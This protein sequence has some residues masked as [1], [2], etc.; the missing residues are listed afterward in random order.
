MKPISTGGASQ[1]SI[2]DAHP[3]T[4][5]S[6]TQPYHD[7]RSATEATH[8]EGIDVAVRDAGRPVDTVMLM[9]D[10]QPKLLP[11]SAAGIAF[12]EQKSED[13]TVISARFG[14]LVKE[15]NLLRMQLQTN[16]SQQMADQMDA[17][18]TRK[19]DQAEQEREKAERVQKIWGSVFKGLTVLLTAASLLAA[20]FTGGATLV[21]TMAIFA[22]DVGMEVGTGKSLTAR[23]VEPVMKFAIETFQKLT[24]ELEKLGLGKEAAIAVAAALSY[25]AVN[26]LVVVLAKV[27]GG[28]ATAAKFIGKCTPKMVQLLKQALQWV[29]KQIGKI[30]V[31]DGGF[32]A[33]AKSVGYVAGAGTGLSQTGNAGQAVAQAHHHHEAAKIEASIVSDSAYRDINNE[34]SEALVDMANHA[35]ELMQTLLASTRRMLN[36]QNDVNANIIANAR[37]A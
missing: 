24:A 17:I 31:G 7:T 1:S 27:G 28:L 35:Q 6:I 10:M 33:S 30:R 18:N 15:R 5:T 32:E 8:A 13:L 25:I 4:P 34:M 36:A 29:M 37:A 22:I 14:M 3:I 21:I 12:A 9:T 20:V 16:L 19:A 2:Q 11:P 23:I 26:I